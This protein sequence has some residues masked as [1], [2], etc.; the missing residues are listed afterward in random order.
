[1]HIRDTYCILNPQCIWPFL[2]PR[3][4]PS[5]D[6]PGSPQA[7]TKPVR[8]IVDCSV[9]KY[10]TRKALRWNMPSRNPNPTKRP[11]GIPTQGANKTQVRVTLG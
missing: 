3:Q 4:T 5:T 6:H 7:K 1:M 2:A 8:R 10:V 9:K 11:L